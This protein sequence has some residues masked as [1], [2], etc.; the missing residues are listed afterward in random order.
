MLCEP[1]VTV[2]PVLARTTQPAVSCTL[3]ERLRSSTKKPTDPAAVISL[4]RNA[5][6]GGTGVSSVCSDASKYAP[7]EPVALCSETASTFVPVTS[8][9]DGRLGRMK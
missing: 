7:A 4:N 1:S 9:A 3:A 6:V 2:C 5:C 8:A